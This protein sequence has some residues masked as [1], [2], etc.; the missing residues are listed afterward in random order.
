MGLVVTIGG[1]HGTGKSTYARLIAR[2]FKL[3]YVSAGQVFRDLAKEKGVSLEE[4]SKQAA[5][6]SE[7]DRLIDERS[8]AEAAK[9]DVVIEGQLAAW[10][11]KDKA[12]IRIYLKAPDQ[13]RINRIA[14][15]DHQDYEVAR[16]QTLEREK[17]QRD[18]YRRY[19]DVNIDD[20][21]LYNVVIDTGNRSVESTSAELM[22]KIREILNPS[23]PR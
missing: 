9:G 8:A 21:S 7:I 6:S 2:Q 20:L 10:M 15:R 23:K 11:A 17:I 3:R 22:S 18:R 16:G 5:R 4:L 12:Q 14:H 13:V 1:P 19:Y